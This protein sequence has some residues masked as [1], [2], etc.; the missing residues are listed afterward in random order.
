MNN[1]EQ[2]SSDGHQMSLTGGRVRA[3]P[4]LMGLGIMG[5]VDMGNPPSV[6][7]QTDTSENITFPNFV[8]G[9]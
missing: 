5:N 1:F 2:V 6:K 4:C 8:G 3:V 7:R 9:R